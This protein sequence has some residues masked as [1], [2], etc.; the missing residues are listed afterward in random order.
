[1]H[2]LWT[3]FRFELQLTWRG[4]M[5][6]VLSV[7]IA[8]VG[9][10]I[11]VLVN[12]V[13]DQWWGNLCLTLG[14]LT[15]LLALTTGNQIQR[16]R[17][18]RLDG[19]L[20]STPLATGS[21]VLG[22]YLAGLFTI[23]VYVGVAWLTFVGLSYLLSGERFYTPALGATVYLQVWLLLIIVPVLFAA[24]LMLIGLTWTRG[25]RSLIS[26][27][28]VIIWLVPYLIRVPKLLTISFY[29]PHELTF[30][31]NSFIGD[32]DFIDSSVK[33]LVQNM[34]KHITPAR[35]QQMVHLYQTVVIPE[36]LTTN[37]L[38]NRAF[39]F[40]LSILLLIS[41]IYVVHCQRQGKM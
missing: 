22:K 37:L 31:G 39:F 10:G 30:D 9:M 15:L 24:A 34:D 20:L 13:D 36:H 41:T 7:V 28:V 33:V 12:K 21:Y 29:M 40:G 35:V 5:G 26:V 3:V 8:F 23:L 6:W 38:V 11:S 25:Q 32:G 16:D 1:M 19:I 17:E 4:T 18:C 14:F 27:L 2:N